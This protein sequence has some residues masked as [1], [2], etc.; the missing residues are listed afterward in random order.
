MPGQPFSK[1]RKDF[2]NCCPILG[3]ITPPPKKR[4]A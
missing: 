4:G 3:D 2:E 1:D